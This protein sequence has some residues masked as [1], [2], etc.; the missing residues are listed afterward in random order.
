MEKDDDD[1]IYMDVL[2]ACNAKLKCLWTPETQT[3]R[4]KTMRR[5]PTQMTA[6]TVVR[7]LKPVSGWK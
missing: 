1:V 2:L 6:S 4:C 5:S 3:A 7:R